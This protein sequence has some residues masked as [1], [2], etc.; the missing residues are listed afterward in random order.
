MPLAPPATSSPTS[1]PAPPAV[2]AHGGGRLAWSGLVL[3]TASD[4]LPVVTAADL[5]T[6]LFPP[7]HGIAPAALETAVRAAG[8]VTGDLLTIDRIVPRPGARHVDRLLPVE[9]GWAGSRAGEPVLFV[10][11]VEQGS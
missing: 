9:G 8:P 11:R 5:W 10:A 7:A 6:T 2:R 1:P 3:G 4:P